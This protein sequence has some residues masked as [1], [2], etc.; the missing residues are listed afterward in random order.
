[1]GEWMDRQADNDCEQDPE[2]RAFAGIEPRVRIE[3]LM[4]RTFSVVIGILSRL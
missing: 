2:K 4:I 3:I 1:M